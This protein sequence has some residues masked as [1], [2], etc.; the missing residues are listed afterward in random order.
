MTTV[1]EAMDSIP[2]RELAAL[3]RVSRATITA[4][5]D[6]G[7]LMD[8]PA[9]RRMRR[10]LEDRCGLDP[11][12]PAAADAQGDLPIADP[13]QVQIKRAELA[14]KEAAAAEKERKNAE[15]E[16]RPAAPDEVAAKVGHAGAL[17]RTVIRGAPGDGSA[18]AR[19]YPRP[20]ILETYDAG[21]TVGI[22]A[23]TTGG[24]MILCDG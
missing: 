23:V 24:G 8:T 13:I 12:D 21:F 2:I 15:A 3:A 5:K 14:M 4:A 9:G 22:G 18:I 7:D 1:R 11:L 16:S 17:L 6:R 10:V 20:A 19:G